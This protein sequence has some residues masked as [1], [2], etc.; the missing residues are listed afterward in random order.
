MGPGIRRP[1]EVVSRG[2]GP[3]GEGELALSVPRG[4]RDACWIVQNARALPVLDGG[5]QQLRASPS[6]VFGALDE[7]LYQLSVC[8]VYFQ[9]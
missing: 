7:M 3:E 5:G 9:K 1:G 4:K 2:V 8:V 6:A